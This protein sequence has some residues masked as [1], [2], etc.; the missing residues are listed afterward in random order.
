MRK[1][2]NGILY[3][4]MTGFTWKD[5]PHL[6]GSKSVIHRFHLCLCEHG[7]LKRFLMTL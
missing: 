6:Y 3:V 5:V 2:I 4:V 7:I 1:L